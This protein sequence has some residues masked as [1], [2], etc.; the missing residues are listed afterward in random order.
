MKLFL[1]A[2]NISVLKK[3]HEIFN[4]KMN[5]LLSYPYRGSAFP[6]FMVQ[7]RDKIDGLILDSGAWTLN[8]TNSG[9]KIMDVPKELI[10]YYQD[11][12]N[13]FDFM[14]NYDSDFSVGG[15]DT[16]YSNQLEMEKAGLSPVAV[17]H[18]FYGKTEIDHYIKRGYKRVAWDHLR[19][20]ILMTFS[21]HP[22]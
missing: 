20:E 7:D 5:V 22:G 16:N 19:E 14:F 3:Y 13:Y 15:F 17:V 11:V 4:T 18:D 8:H 10:F 2:M 21:M 9:K 1:A 6:K 12:E